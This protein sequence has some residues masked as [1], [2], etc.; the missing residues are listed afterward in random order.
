VDFERKWRR[1]QLAKAVTTSAVLPAALGLWAAAFPLFVGWFHSAVPLLDDHG[2]HEATYRMGAFLRVVTMLFLLGPLG[3]IIGGIVGTIVAI[4]IEDE[5]GTY[6]DDLVLPWFW[7]VGVTQVGLGT[8]VLA[9]G[10]SI[11][12]TWGAAVA[13]TA[14]VTLTTPALCA[15]EVA[16]QRRYDAQRRNP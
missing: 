8:A 4:V 5:L 12:W 10:L 3:F 11:T 13:W 16:A 15:Y 2:T 6:P 1:N 9:L 14:L 7:G